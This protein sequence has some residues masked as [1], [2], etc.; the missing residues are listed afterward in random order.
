MQT[1]LERATGPVAGQEDYPLLGIVIGYGILVLVVWHFHGLLWFPAINRLLSQSSTYEVTT[2]PPSFAVRQGDRPSLGVDE[3]ARLRQLFENRQ[4]ERLEKEF[5]LLQEAFEEDPAREYAVNDAWGIFGYP[6]P[7]QQ[8]GFDAWIAH[9]PN[10]FAPYLARACYFVGK[11]WEARGGNFA[12]ET[13]VDQFRGM[14]EFFHFAGLDLDRAMWL[15]SRLLPAY[16]LRLDIENAQ[17]ER[18][19]EIKVFADARVLFP[20]SFLLYSTLLHTRLPRWG[21]SYEEMESLSR[22]ALQR[23]DKNPEMYLLFG[24]IYQDQARKMRR[25]GK[26]TKAVDLSSK[27]LRFGGHSDFFEERARNYLC[28][29][30]LER[31]LADVKQAIGLRP[32]REAPHRLCATILLNRGDLDGALREIAVARQLSPWKSAVKSWDSW[33][34]GYLMRKGHAV[35]GEHLSEALLFYDRALEL[36][37]NHAET[38]YWRGIGHDR[39]GQPDKALADV[40]QSLS[41]DPGRFEAYRLLDRLLTKKGQRGEV[42]AAW[43][44]FIS[45]QPDHADAH[46]ERAGTYR[47]MGNMPRA[48]ADLKR[49]C[50]LGSQEA[51]QIQQRH[52]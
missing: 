16:L 18:G 42:V 44:R 8:Q 49:A 30:D 36:D 23:V 25:E 13:S 20:D 47:H 21:G 48:L 14:R 4:F 34:A 12:S 43:D 50:D 46:L 19:G 41:S 15:K 39:Q 22:Q 2:A 1:V 3:L 45:L 31:A 35:F 17:G 9:S 26:F 6:P 37:P 5:S 40:R 51:C 38:L 32:V 27:A 52:R 33:A 24:K 10:H 7:D 28:L 29:R 11:G